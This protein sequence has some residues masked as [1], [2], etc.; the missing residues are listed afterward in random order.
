MQDWTDEDLYRPAQPDDT[1]SSTRGMMRVSYRAES[2]RGRRYPRT[3]AVQAEA[4][5]DY[6]IPVEALSDGVFREA[7][8]ISGHA[9]VYGVA[10]YAETQRGDLVPMPLLIFTDGQR[11]HHI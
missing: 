4:S 9:D 10:I 5:S 8:D 7:R 2:R 6:R 11:G 1:V 3:P